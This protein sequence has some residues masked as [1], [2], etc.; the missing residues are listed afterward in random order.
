MLAVG[1]LTLIAAFKTSS[2]AELSP[3]DAPAYSLRTPDAG[4]SFL[5]DPSATICESTSSQFQ[6][7]DTATV[8]KPIGNP[9][10]SSPFPI[11]DWI[12]FGAAGDSLDITSTAGK[13]YTNLGQQHDSL[14]NAVPY[15]RARLP[16][17]GAVAIST[18]MY[19]NEGESVAYTLRIERVGREPP[20][21][22]RPTCERATLAVI[23]AR[24]TD[25]FSIVPLS[26]V[27]SVHD[28]SNW[29]VFTGVY[30]VALVS[31]SLYQVC[32]VPCV[33]PDTIEL[34]P[35]TT[36]TRDY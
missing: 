31:D 9:R 34:L 33:K 16:N 2:H 11:G 12:W 6:F 26:I 7:I 32:R 4:G 1:M 36:V 19:E 21:A 30:K 20:L 10:Y 3:A 8:R 29:T 22:L 24:L 27:D 15:F 25:H 28:L 23:S 18:T 35:G 17:D 14:R 13:V 5:N